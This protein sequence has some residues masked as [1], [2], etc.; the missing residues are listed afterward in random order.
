VYVLLWPYK[1]CYVMFMV[2]YYVT[3]LIDLIYDLNY[4]RFKLTYNFDHLTRE[5]ELGEGVIN[6]HKND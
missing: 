5:V 3:N 6:E 1:K 2:C 4:D